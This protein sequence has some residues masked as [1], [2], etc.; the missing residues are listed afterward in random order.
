MEQ[1]RNADRQAEFLSI[2]LKAQVVLGEANT[3]LS[4]LL[5][6]TP[7]MIV[8]T[9]RSANHTV[10][11]RVN[12]KTVA[13]G[14]VVMVGNN[15]GFYVTKI[16][17]PADRGCKEDTGASGVAERFKD[18]SVN[19][20]GIAGRVRKPLAGLLSL[21]AG[22]L[23]EFDSPKA[24]TAEITANGLPVARAEVVNIQGYYGLKMKTL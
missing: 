13:H 5:P 22:S 24:A 11:L 12:G 9:G 4:R 17:S 21:D 18:I 3:D 14:E 10:D 15:Y 19:I 7:G 23:I 8:D 20:Q 6:L 1:E 2:P 16:L